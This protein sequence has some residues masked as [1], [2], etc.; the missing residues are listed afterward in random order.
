[1]KI[2]TIKDIISIDA[3]LASL[4]LRSDEAINWINAVENGIKEWI[5]NHNKQYWEI[6]RFCQREK[7]YTR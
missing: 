3:E 5:G 4:F 6:V 7:G 1:M 2:V